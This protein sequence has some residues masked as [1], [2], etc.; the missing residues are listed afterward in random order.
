MENEIPQST[1]EPEVF[2][3]R[4]DES[5]HNDIEYDPINN[6]NSSDESEDYN[7]TKYD[8]IN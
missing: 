7:D 2:D 8:R 1:I 5:G 6:M 4:S 3:Y